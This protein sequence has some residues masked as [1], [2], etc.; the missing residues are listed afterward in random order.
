V[1]GSNGVALP[2]ISLISP[3][4]RSALPAKGS[5]ALMQ[6]SA[7]RDINKDFSLWTGSAEGRF[8]CNGCGKDMLPDSRRRHACAQLK[9]KWADH[10]AEAATTAQQQP[11]EPQ[12]VAEPEQPHQQPD[13][14]PMHDVDD[15]VAKEEWWDAQQPEE[16]EAAREQAPV[17]PVEHYYDC[18]DE[19]QAVSDSDDF[20]DVGWAEDQWEPDPDALPDAA[21]GPHSPAEQQQQEQQQQQHQEHQQQHQEHQQQQQ[22]RM[23]EEEEEEEE[24][25]LEEGGDQPAPEEERGSV[26]RT[27]QWY[28]VR[29]D[30]PLYPGQRTTLR[31][32]VLF[33][34]TWRHSHHVGKQA[35]DQ[36]LRFMAFEAFPA[37]NLL[38]SSE[39]MMQRVIGSNGWRS[40]EHHVCDA[41]GCQGHVWDPLPQK[42]WQA[43]KDD[44]CPL[45]SK[46][47]FVVT[48]RGGKE[49]LQP[50]R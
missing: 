29:L 41:E 12:P 43:H 17:V 36:L 11:Q 16:E 31:D 22:Q 6:G 42:H 7:S 26:K 8:V 24:E 1:A 3:P 32:A 48:K 37:D 28:K 46:P 50:N 21:G 33:L 13:D 35:F 20:E 18:E 34:M 44:A 19:A 25:L 47:R 39:Y 10:E 23:D 9:R 40:R 38:P 4:P 30:Q 5:R 49:V 14:Q 27:V 2:N 45:C 15:G